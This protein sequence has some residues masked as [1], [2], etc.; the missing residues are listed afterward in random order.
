MPSVSL[1]SFSR[2]LGVVGFHSGTLCGSLVSFGSVWF[3]QARL[4]GRPVDLGALGSFGSILGV[5]GFIR[6]RRGHSGSMGSFGRVIR[7]V[8]FIVVG[9]VHALRSLG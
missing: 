5:N 6:E 9:W 1:G 3:I 4:W 8:G 7:V 2:A